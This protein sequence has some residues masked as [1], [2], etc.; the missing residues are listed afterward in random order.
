MWRRNLLWLCGVS[1]VPQI[2]WLLSVLQMQHSSS[3]HVATKALD[4]HFTDTAL[5]SKDLEAVFVLFSKWKLGQLLL[6]Q[7]LQTT[8]NMNSA[9]WRT[10][11]SPTGLKIQMWQ[12]IQNLESIISNN[13]LTPRRQVWGISVDKAPLA[14]LTATSWTQQPIS[15]SAN[16]PLHLLDNF[17]Q[18]HTSI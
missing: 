4:S 11:Q 12:K 3:D 8:L 14:P 2:I 15:V 17:C 7:H 6:A 1:F 9:K 18:D 5:N 13:P 16:Q 10:L